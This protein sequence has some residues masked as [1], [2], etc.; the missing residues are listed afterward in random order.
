MAMLNNQMVIIH[1]WCHQRSGDM[2]VWYQIDPNW[3]TPKSKKT[4][5]VMLSFKRS[6]WF[7]GTTK[8]ENHPCVTKTTNRLPQNVKYPKQNPGV[9]LA[10]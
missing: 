9:G 2:G 5:L 6:Q 4:A 10:F 8:L 3:R 1:M 7:W